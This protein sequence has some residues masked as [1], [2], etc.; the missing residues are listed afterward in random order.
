MA[1]RVVKEFLATHNKTGSTEVCSEIGP[2]VL[3]ETII[4]HVHTEQATAIDRERH[5]HHHQHRVQPIVATEHLA[6]EHITQIQPAVV[7]E[8]HEE[9]APEKLEMLEKLKTQHKNTRT[10]A[11]TEETVAVLGTTAS[12][13]VHHHVHEHI[14]PVIHKETHQHKI[15]HNV[16]PIHEKIHESPIVHESTV[17]PT[18]T[19][20]EF[21]AK[22][23][24]A[25]GL[26][27]G[28]KEHSH[29]YYEGQPRVSEDGSHPVGTKTVVPANGTSPVAVKS[30]KI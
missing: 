8:R 6:E 3:Q 7:Q 25:K 19:M 26:H 17:L 11:P 22:M 5:I 30:P 20:E 24:Q 29:H 23:A 28:E 13:H 14:T 4:P 12:E 10:I 9:M 1:E 27:H 21:R 18:L 2:E 15:I 16:I